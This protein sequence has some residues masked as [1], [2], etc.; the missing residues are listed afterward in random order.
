MSE[1]QQRRSSIKRRPRAIK[2]ASASDPTTSHSFTIP[3]THL[4]D[5]PMATFVETVQG[6][7]K[8]VL[9]EP[10]SVAP[11]SPVKR[12]RMQRTSS[13]TSLPLPDLGP[14]PSDAY[15][16]AYTISL[17]DEEEESSPPVNSQAP[18]PKKKKKT[19]NVADP[20]MAEWVSDYRESYLSAL[21]W[22]D[23]RGRSTNEV[24]S[25]DDATQ[26]A[27]Y[28]C[29]DCMH[30][31]LLCKGC[32]V[33]SHELRPFHSI[34]EWTGSYFKRRS[35][36]SLGVRLQLGHPPGE[37]CLS[38]SADAISTSASTTQHNCYA[39]GCTPPPVLGPGLAQHLRVWTSS[40]LSLHGKTSTYDYYHAGIPN[41]RFRGQ[42]I[43]PRRGRGHTSAAITET[44]P[45][46]LAIR[47]A[48]C[49]R[50]D[51]NL[52][53]DW[54]DAAPADQCL[55]VLFIAL[56]ACFRLKRRLVGSDLRDPGLGTG[57]AYFVEWEPYRQYLLTVTDQKE[58]STC[59]GLAALDHA[60][61][62]FARGYSATGVGAGICA[63]HEFVLPNGVGDLQRGERYANM[64]YILASLLRHIHQSLR[65]IFSYD[66][67]CQW[68]KYL[69]ERLLALP[70]L[71]RLKLALEL[72]QF[73]VPK[74]HINAHIALCRLLF[75]L[76]LILGSGMTDGEGIEPAMAREQI[77]SDDHW[78]FWNWSKL[79][80]LAKLLRR[81]LANA[82]IEAR[83]QEDSFRVFST[84]QAE[85]VGAWLDMVR[86]F[87][88][89]NTQPNPYASSSPDALTEAELRKTLEEED[90]SAR[91]AGSIVLHSVGPSE[92]IIF[93]LEL[94]GQQRNLRVQ[95]QMKRHGTTTEPIRLRPLRK[96]LGKNIK[97]LRDL[98]AT[99]TPTALT[100]LASLDLPEDVLVED[101]P[102]LLPS[103]IPTSL[104]NG[105]KD[106][107]L[108]IECRLRHAQCQSALAQLRHQLHMKAR[109]LI[110][111]K[112]QSRHQGMN[113]LPCSC[114]S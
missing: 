41:K 91:N 59:T 114:R 99:Y 110:Y 21:L 58:I 106:G 36:K 47:C 94:E 33:T 87:E 82:K 19:S 77:S 14:A 86:V 76:A 2:G 4:P 37:S 90:Q 104:R 23:G 8:R 15:T 11:S 44:R 88:A 92:F 95:A 89:D 101:I 51:V 49:P 38:I 93:G 50:P 112:L 29:S 103:G 70:A 28:R 81:R 73:A 61:T 75:S 57:W 111:K 42:A 40:T 43:G 20:C 1:P 67:A 108:E 71:V 84:Q 31:P 53:P 85:H 10:A 45:G 72:C 9:R 46:E 98:Q 105:C 107:L 22:L 7:S 113:T 18:R 55:Y 48:A 74:M 32:I 79:V 56:D 96:K 64:D 60:N 3:T 25:C 27:V 16:D 69:K 109:L 24:C 68:G 39:L 80:G 35:L 34:E 26:P 12:M 13:T 52:P 17:W 65:K 62:K 5:A 97:R 66:I 63:R 6:T 30:G 78:S 100:H 54:K 83:R 102:L